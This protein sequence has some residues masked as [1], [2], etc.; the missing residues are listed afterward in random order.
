MLEIAAH[1]AACTFVLGHKFGNDVLR[2]CD[3]FIGRRNA[4]FRIHIVGQLRVQ[5]HVGTRHLRLVE[6]EHGQW[7]K[8]LLAGNHGAR[9]AFR[10]IGQV[11]VLEFGGVPA[12]F[13]ASAQFVGQLALFVDGVEDGFLAVGEFLQ[14]G[15]LGVDV[16]NLHLVEAAGRLLAVA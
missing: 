12:L 14:F 8:P 6:H 1:G 3:S 15:V 7:F 9:A 16:G 2:A 4:L 13:D 10:P 5:R 11:D